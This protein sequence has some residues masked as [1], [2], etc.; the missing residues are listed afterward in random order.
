MQLKLLKNYFKR[1]PA[2]RFFF[3]KRGDFFF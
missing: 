2:I 3:K 1:F